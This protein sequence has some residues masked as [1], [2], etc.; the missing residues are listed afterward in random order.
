M[1]TAL[2]QVWLRLPLC[3]RAMSEDNNA[4]C[5]F[6]PVERGMVRETTLGLLLLLIGQNFRV[7]ANAASNFFCFRD[8]SSAFC[9]LGRCLWN[10]ARSINVFSLC[11]VRFLCMIAASFKIVISSDDVLLR[12]GKSDG[13]KWRIKACSIAACLSGCS[14]LSNIVTK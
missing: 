3:V 2:V 4:P 12:S 7:P 5:L 9:S 6:S 10:A 14:M 11:S 8:S 1:Q 13:G